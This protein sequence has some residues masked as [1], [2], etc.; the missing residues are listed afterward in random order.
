M[1]NINEDIKILQ[2]SLESVGEEYD[3]S[4]EKQALENLIKGYRELEEKNEDLLIDVYNLFIPK[5][6]VKEI[7]EEL[8]NWDS[9]FYQ[10]VIHHN[11]RTLTELVQ[12]ILQELMED[13]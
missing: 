3:V 12:N 9:E 1:N 10:R 13:K 4:K 7:I 5:S 11:E 8:D 6:K 2:E